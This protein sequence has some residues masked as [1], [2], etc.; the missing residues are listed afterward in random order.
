MS[1]DSFFGRMV[2]RASVWA[3]TSP[4]GTPLMPW[5]GTLALAVGL[6]GAG[7]RSLAQNTAASA[8]TK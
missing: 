5:W 6:T 8:L 1:T 4:T 2:M 7:Y 3:D